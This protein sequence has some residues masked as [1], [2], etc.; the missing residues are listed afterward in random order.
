[1]GP[2]ELV[3]WKIDL[4]GRMRDDRRRDLPLPPPDF[5]LAL[6][7]EPSEPGPFAGGVD[8]FIGKLGG[9]ESGRCGASARVTAVAGAFIR[10]GTSSSGKKLGGSELEGFGWDQIVQLKSVSPNPK[11]SLRSESLRYRPKVKAQ[12]LLIKM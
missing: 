12:A 8:D 5:P 9:N 10:R 3:S 2:A 1:M 4:K 11:D 7:V 6:G